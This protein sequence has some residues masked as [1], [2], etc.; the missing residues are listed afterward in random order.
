[1]PTPNVVRGSSSAAIAEEPAP[2]QPAAGYGLR[3]N[4]LSPVE[5]FAQSV[6]AIAPSTIP[7]FAVPMVAGLAGN[8]AWLVYIVAM[9]AM[10]LVGL[11][12]SVFARDSS[13][14]GSLYVYV[15]GNLPPAFAAVVAW[16]LLFAYISTASSIMGAIISSLVGWHVQVIPLLLPSLIVVIAFAIAYREVKVSA[17]IMLWVEA[18]SLSLILIVIMITLWKRG[19]AIDPAQ[20]HLRGVTFSSARL[21]V[22]LAIFGFVGFESAAALGS[23]AKDPLRT[24]P[25]AILGSAL[26]AGVFFI[27][28]CYAETA[29]FHSAGRSL[30]E[31]SAPLRFLASEGGVPLFGVFIDVGV[32]VALFSGVI[33]CIIASARVLLVMAHDGLLP[34][35]LTKTHAR[36]ETPV[37]AAMIA[38]LAM[39]A[40]VTALTL[41]GVT[42]AEVYGLLG[43]VAVFGFL[44]AYGVVAAA[45]PFHLY[46]RGR[47]GAGR[48]ALSLGAT[49][50]IFLA[51]LLS[52]Y[53]IPP[54]PY[55]YLPLI[56][57]SYLIV[58]MS[59]YVVIRRKKA[60]S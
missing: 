21:G 23:K 31:A 17:Q 5:V 18:A 27:L 2:A 10:M 38:V 56:Y 22:M 47:L 11:C 30:G 16:G 46:Q 55:R 50:I 3:Q 58:G 49:L 48:I 40:P 57:V 42:G 13:S 24:I 45:M 43:T 19:F 14:P 51:V 12:I 25:Q 36:N 60:K 44:T 33:A 59:W 15:R 52:I 7:V 54:A 28:C 34:V 26:V 41:R 35:W 29:G 4:A 6:A 20:L 37:A 1:M 9:A 32:L 53:P 8:G 39:D